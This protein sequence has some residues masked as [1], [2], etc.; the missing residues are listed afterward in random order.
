ML[1]YK[2]EIFRIFFPFIAFVYVAIDRLV[3]PIALYL[4]A[5]LYLYNKQFFLFAFSFGIMCLIMLH[6][7]QN[8]LTQQTSFKGIVVDK[9]L[10]REFP[11]LDLKTNTGTY[12]V[13]DETLSYNIGDYIVVKGH[14]ERPL[15]NGFFGGF[16]YQAYLRSV[17]VSGVIYPKDHFLLEHNSFNMHQIRGKLHDYIDNTFEEKG[18]IKAF[19]LASRA[20]LDEGQYET[21]QVL[22]VAHLFA[23]SGLHVG[24]LVITINKGLKFFVKQDG[25]RD[26]LIAMF[27]IGY[28]FITGYPPSVLRASLMVCLLGVNKH[29][30]LEFSSLDCVLILCMALIMIH[31]FYLYQVGFKLSFLI[32]ITLILSKEILKDHDVY[33]QAFLVSLIAFSVSVPIVLTMQGAIN[34]TS[35]IFNVIYVALMSILVLP[36][37]YIVFFIPQIE[38]I[39]SIVI[40]GFEYTADLFL[41]WA[42]LPLYFHIPPGVL[43][44][45][46][47]GLVYFALSA[48]SFQRLCR[49]VFV[50]GLY[51]LLLI[52]SP[53]LNPTQSLIMYDVRGDGFLLRD[54]FNQCNILIDTGDKDNHNQLVNALRRKNIRH[55]DLVLISHKHRDHYGAYATIDKSFQIGETIT[56]YSMENKTGYW[57]QCGNI[58][59]YIFPNEIPYQN[60]NENSMIV[61]IKFMEKTILFTGDIE[62]ER[63]IEFLNQ[64]NQRIDILKVAHHGSISSSYKPLIKTL[65][66]SIVLVPAH[67]NNQFGHPHETVI[68]RFES[69][70][71]EIYRLDHHGSVHI[72]KVGSII[73][74]KTAISP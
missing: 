5:R 34:L 43:T 39:Y 29:L 22:G 56:N 6:I 9:D 71:S 27:L 65:D 70:G 63:E 73:T 64:F 67:R 10:N 15:E 24:F 31:P 49:R 59:Y 61:L 57:H 11:R 18:Y 32:S 41:K 46:Y 28:L 36:L 33:I 54:A 55:I 40:Q 17:N 26:A 2:G 8:E 14:A 74:K 60:E 4:L 21:F 23:V 1:P 3:F 19:L 72:R 20:Q 50:V 45:I 69:F 66:P 37:T 62:K 38:P 12:I 7:P 47:I 68:E 51:C 53:F 30:K 44:F 42:S 35:I 48:E 16:D 25:I 13:Y 52:F 58:Q